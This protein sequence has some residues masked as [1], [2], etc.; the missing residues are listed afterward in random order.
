MIIV[1]MV[2]VMILVRAV[3]PGLMLVN[4]VRRAEVIVDSDAQ[5]VIF[6][7]RS[8]DEIIARAIGEELRLQLL[9]EV[10]IFEARR[11]AVGDRIGKAGSDGKFH[12]RGLR[13]LRDELCV[14][15]WHGVEKF[16]GPARA[17]G[18]DAARHIGKP[19]S[20]REAGATANGREVRA[21]RTPLQR[22]GRRRGEAGAVRRV[23]TAEI[24]ELGLE[25]IDEAPILPVVSGMSAGGDATRLRQNMR[26]EIVGWRKR[27]RRAEE[28]LAIRRRDR[29]AVSE[30]A[31]K[32][33]P[34]DL[35]GVSLF[36][37]V[38][39]PSRFTCNEE[40]QRRSQQAERLN[41]EDAGARSG[42][43]LF[44][45]R[46]CL[47]TRWRRPHR[48]FRCARPR[49]AGKPAATAALAGPA[50]LLNPHVCH[51]FETNPI[52]RAILAFR[53]SVIIIFQT[54]QVRPRHDSVERN[55]PMPKGLWSVILLGAVLLF[56]GSSL[57]GWAMG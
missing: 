33:G 55:T 2:M 30:A 14:K 53:P 19:G 17:A 52:C 5:N 50:S 43:R 22:I 3:F 9:I 29:N 24:V 48:V 45:R 34:V 15:T 32:S 1:I 10:K 12:A 37:R 8:R 54:P 4:L 23:A 47:L 38:I 28:T 16:R 57:I 31:V 40:R 13:G 35:R 20:H 27:A 49:V 18:C 56:V 25:A 39:G 36:E 42:R 6:R 7:S 46:R 21:A 44:V 51:N 11:P 26:I 41:G